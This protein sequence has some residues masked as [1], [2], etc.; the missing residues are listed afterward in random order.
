MRQAHSSA[1]DRGA[2]LV[3]LAIVLPLLVTLFLIA[4]DFGVVVR[5]H[6]ILQNAAREGARFS[7]L[8]QNWVS[9]VNPT[10][11]QDA[12][13]QVVVDYLAEENITVDKGAVTVNQQYPITVGTLTLHGS[14]I[15]VTYTRPLLI[16]GAPLLPVGQITLT[17]QSV[18]RN[19]Y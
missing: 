12:I 11:T 8:P 6:Q 2:A 5:E 19:L 3:E 16:V 10:A 13:K 4:V 17:G 14:Q 7:I 9:P 18:F 15:T 1:A